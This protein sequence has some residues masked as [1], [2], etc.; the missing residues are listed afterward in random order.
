[1]QVAGKRIA[2]RY[3]I[4]P[5][6]SFDISFARL[7]DEPRAAARLTFHETGRVTRARNDPKQLAHKSCSNA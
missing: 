6:H 7:S 5:C 2:T 1:M 3:R 4:V